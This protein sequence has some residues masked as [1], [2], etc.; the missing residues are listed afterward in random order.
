MTEFLSPKDFKHKYIVTVRF[1]EV[2]MLGVC[3]NAVYINFFETARLEYIKAA[4]L[5]PEKGIFSDDKIFFMVRNEINYRSHAYY[6]DVLEVYSRISYIKN[7][8]F[9]YDH[10]IVQQKTGE[11]IVDGKGV[12]VFVDPK[13]RKSTALPESFNEKVKGF[14]PSVKILRD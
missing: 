5:M 4:G 7:S 6:D 2:D 12:V 11:V 9:G 10:L 13:T 8:S 14:E 3:N 1:H